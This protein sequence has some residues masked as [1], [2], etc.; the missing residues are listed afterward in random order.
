MVK[1]FLISVVIMLL[2][3][4]T[5]PQVLEDVNKYE[6]RDIK[7]TMNLASKSL[8]NSIDMGGASYEIF[9]LGHY[10]ENEDLIQIDQDRLIKEFN[11]VLYKNTLNPEYMKELQRRI[12]L[13]VLS[14]GDRFYVAE[15]KLTPPANG[16]RQN[17]EEWDVSYVWLPPIYYNFVDDAGR[18]IYVTARDEVGTYYQG[19]GAT[20]VPMKVDLDTVTKNGVPVTKQMKE[21]LIV[22]K[23][24]SVVLA[25][26]VDPA[27]LNGGL[28]I[29]IKPDGLEDLDISSYTAEQKDEYFELLYELDNFNILDGI[30][31]FIV[32][33]EDDVRG[34]DGTT[35]HYTN[36]N[37][38]GFTLSKRY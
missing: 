18:L 6:K 17:I 16:N 24:N 32:Y 23:L 2:C 15:M 11:D 37:A 4:I 13:M 31:F 8:V 35:F 7:T 38:T 30:T 9:S 26:T 29:R 33:S 20:E 1:P 28:K 19:Y 10:L 22:E 36:Y 21:E 25:K 12:P 34:F 14:Y 27:N 5:I 3:Y